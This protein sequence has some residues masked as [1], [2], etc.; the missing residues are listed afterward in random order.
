MTV[1]YYHLTSY[2]FNSNFRFILVTQMFQTISVLSQLSVPMEKMLLSTFPSSRTGL[3]CYQKW[4]WYPVFILVLRE[5]L[6]LYC[7]ICL[8]EMV[9]FGNKFNKWPY[10]FLFN[11]T[12]VL[13]TGAM[14]VRCFLSMDLDSNAETVMTLIFV[15]H[16][17]K[18]ENIMQGI[19]LAE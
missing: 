6:F 12:A 19:H 7:Q 2:R 10:L 13:K 9:F 4:S 14:A 18:P 16:V 1:I 3:G 11:S 5:F 15:K 17:S 8:G